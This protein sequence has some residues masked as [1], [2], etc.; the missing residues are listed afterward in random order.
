MTEEKLRLENALNDAD[1]ERD[2][3]NTDLERLS[4]QCYDFEKHIVILNEEKNSEIEE[5]R[6]DY[7]FIK[8]S[9][10]NLKQQSVVLEDNLNK[11]RDEK[12]EILDNLKKVQDER[13]GFIRSLTQISEQMQSI[14][15]END[16][17]KKEN[18]E[19]REKLNSK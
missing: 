7:C 18:E 6:A 5:T 3:M 15:L 16:E 8:Q 2:K 9:Y 4:D 12:L 17:L 11:L 10:E 19:L 14:E 1:N 13:F